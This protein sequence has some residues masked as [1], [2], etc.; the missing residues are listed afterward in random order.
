MFTAN[1]TGWRTSSPTT[2]TRLVWVL[3]SILFAL[4]ISRE[5]LL[6]ILLG[7]ASPA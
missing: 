6:A 3:I 1:V 5:R 2:V 7:F 4:R